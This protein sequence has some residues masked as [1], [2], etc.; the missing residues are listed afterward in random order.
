MF[1]VVAVLMLLGIATPGWS[2]IQISVPATNATGT[3]QISWPHPMPPWQPYSYTVYESVNGG[4]A[5]NLIYSGIGNSWEPGVTVTLTRPSGTYR[6]YLYA[7]VMLWQGPEPWFEWYNTQGTVT[8]NIPPQIPSPPLNLSATAHNAYGDFTVSWSPVANATSYRL[9]RSGSETVTSNTSVSFSNQP[10]G[11]NTFDVRA[12]NGA[13]CSAWSNQI[14]FLV[15]N[16]PAVPT[17]SAT[18]TPNSGNYTVSWSSPLGAHTYKVYQTIDG[19]PPSIQT[20]VNSS[21]N[22]VGSASGD[23]TYRVMACNSVGN[24]SAQSSPVAVK[25][26]R[27][28][29]PPHV[30]ATNL[31][32]AGSY[33]VSWAATGATSYQVRRR[34]RNLDGSYGAWSTPEAITSSSRVYTDTQRGIFEYQA[35]ACNVMGCSAWSAGKEV[36]VETLTYLAA[37]PAIETATAAGAMAFATAISNGG[38]AI[39][40]IPLATPAGIGGLQP[41]LALSYSSGGA[42]QAADRREAPN[43]MRHGWQLSGISTIRR[44]RMLIGGEIALSTADRLC[45]D[46]RPLELVMGASYW[47]TDAQYRTYPN[48]GIKVVAKGAYND[49]W[50]EVF[51]PDGRKRI[52]GDTPQSKATPTGPGS[53]THFHTWGLTEERD[54]FGNFMS[55]D[56][57]LNT[58]DGS[59]YPYLIEY[60]G[61]KI[62]LLYRAADTSGMSVGPNGQANIEQPL[63]L[64]TVRMQWGGQRIREYRIEHTDPIIEGAKRIQQCAYDESGS[65]YRCMAPLSFGWVTHLANIAEFTRSIDT[66]DNGLGDITSFQYVIEPTPGLDGA[67]PAANQDWFGTYAQPTNVAPNSNINRRVAI[68][69]RTPDGRG[70]QTVHTFKYTGRGLYDQA[71]MGF[72]GFPITEVGTD[73]PVFDPTTG[74]SQIHHLSVKRQHRLDRPMYGRVARTETRLSRLGTTTQVLGRTETDWQLGPSNNVLTPRV[75]EWKFQPTS[76]GASQWS[77]ASVT[78]TEYCFSALATP[79]ACPSAIT[80]EFPGQVTTTT[81]LGTSLTPSGTVTGGSLWGSVGT[82]TISGQLNHRVRTTNLLH[83]ATQWWNVGFVGYLREGFGTTSVISTIDTRSQRLDLKG[84]R[85]LSVTELPG[86]AEFNLT[87]TWSYDGRGNVTQE[88]ISGAD[89]A[90]RSTTFNDYAS[91]AY[92]APRTV[93]NAKSQST[94]L[95]YDRRFNTPKSATDPN[96]LTSHT[97]RDEFGRVIRITQPD[98]SITSIQYESCTFAACGMIS[99]GTPRMRVTRTRTNNGQVEPTTRAYLDGLGRELLSETQAFNSADGWTRVGTQYDAAGRVSGQSMP[100]FSNGGAIH[101]QRT[102][103]DSRSRPARLTRTNDTHITNSYVASAVG[104]LTVTS[105]DSANNHQKH[106]RF[107]ALGQLISTTDG[108]GSTD[109][110]TTSY[111]YMAEGDLD[112]VRVNNVQVAD[113]DYDRAGNRNR[114]IDASAG[115]TLFDYDALGQL[116]TS[117]DARGQVTRYSFDVLGRLTERVDAQGTSAEVVNTWTWDTTAFGI[118]ALA[119]RSNANGRFQ[120]TY[121][122]DSLG[123]PQSRTMSTNLAGFTATGTYGIQY[124]Y[125]TQGRLGSVTYPGNITFT[126]RYTSHGYLD[127]LR[128]GSTVLEEYNQLDAFGHVTR[129]TAGNNLIT[130]R[131]FDARTGA[132]TSIAT[133]LAATPKSI[134]DLEYRWQQ[135]GMLERRADQ[136]GTAS[137]ADDRIESFSYDALNRLNT[138]SAVVPGSATRTRTQD[139]DLY[140]NLTSMSSTV[141][142]D[143]GL[144]NAVFGTS[145]RPHRLTSV[146]LGG[147]ATTLT[148]DAAGNLTR[149][150]PNT[151]EST[152]IAYDGAHQATR[153]TVGASLDASTPTA[154]DDFWYDPDGARFLRKESWRSGS[155]Q[156]SRWVLYLQGGTFEEV[157]TPADPTIAYYQ[158]VQV[159]P[160]VQYRLTRTKAGATS[161]AYDYLHRDHLGSVDTITGE[162]GSV[163]HRLSHDPFGARRESN[164][165]SDLTT[166]SLNTILAANSTHTSRGFTDHEHLDRTGIVHMNGRLYDP[167]MGRFL[168]PDPF[169]DNPANSQSYNRYAYVRNQPLALVD[170]SGFMADGIEEIITTGSRGGPNVVITDMRRTVFHFPENEPKP[171]LIHDIQTHLAGTTPADEVLEEVI[172]GGKALKPRRPTISES[173]ANTDRHIAELE[174]LLEMGDGTTP[175]VPQYTTVD[176]ADDLI[177]IASWLP[178]LKPLKLLSAGRA[179]KAARGTT[180]VIGRTKDLGNLAKGERS[181]LDRLTPDLGNAQANWARNSGVLREEMRRGLPIRDASPGDTAGTFLNAERALLKDRGW[182]FDSRTNFWN[183]PGP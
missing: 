141:A 44:C 131:G 66:I 56:W 7:T 104:E 21:I 86:D 140:G 43:T 34:P 106:S 24:C 128:Q 133:G 35:Q 172:V 37:P 127:Q 17:I 20:A 98:G 46:N 155:T 58:V 107:N 82:R 60:N 5:N 95:S 166:P 72:V 173:R 170:P 14:Q 32:Y 45:L 99:W 144:S 39:V 74:T 71:G 90:N 68:A 73:V 57:G 76:S 11:L 178:W 63:L 162:N 157:Q 112:I 19:N 75:Y 158:K 165:S 3:F 26:I 149:Y 143:K 145:S 167:R 54:E 123:R 129:Q 48:T 36:K 117:T 22:Y 138:A 81:R 93:T 53:A 64:H 130:T 52:Y 79:A 153:I 8:V 88:S 18:P 118:G 78:T 122:Y 15:M 126:H 2:Q 96:G 87:R 151:G 100:Y 159:T 50:F 31:N 152:F 164:W 49:R 41:S 25:V 175:Y 180:T 94:T 9:R 40:S 125:D 105:V 171:D 142:G 177:G 89:I 136:R 176:G 85:P 146:T 168:Q 115:T 91:N 132:L 137:T 83:S 59:N 6:Y 38:D 16:T 77:S 150:T 10:Y 69:R 70:G 139:Y 61:A 102:D 154:R 174:A 183:P 111:T 4:P 121:A 84:L 65:S 97:D 23:Y 42:R 120:E 67:E 156:H 108:V 148:Y 134:Q 181:L 29:N 179:A 92:L 12:C 119:S 169:V 47:A 160:T 55:I 110:I 80:T 161:V 13:A 33:T 113:F 116:Q 163:L 147:V 1:R 30:T 114:L 27:I 103:Y 135:D 109:A 124:G 62:E 182:T 28:P 51:L 101:W